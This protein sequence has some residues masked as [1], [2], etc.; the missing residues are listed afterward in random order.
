MPTEVFE[1][2]I[3][4]LSE[5]PA[6]HPLKVTLARINEPLL[7]RRLEYFHDLIAARLPNTRFTFWSNGTVLRQGA[8]EWMSNHRGFYARGLPQRG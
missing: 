5:I 2:I 6:G 1:K 8:F 4:D 3:S 7:D